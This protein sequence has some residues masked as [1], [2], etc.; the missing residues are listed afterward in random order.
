[1]EYAACDDCG[2]MV[3]LGS[4]GWYRC[5]FCGHE[6]LRAV[7]ESKGQSSGRERPAGAPRLGLSLSPSK[8]KHQ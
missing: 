8:E 7:V 5:R 4:M 2:T 3:V 6:S 1:M